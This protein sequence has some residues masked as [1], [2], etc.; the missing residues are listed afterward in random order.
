MVAS[1]YEL[2]QLGRKKISE[3][4]LAFVL[5]SIVVMHFICH[6]L[7]VFMAIY[8]VYLIRQAKRLVR[9][10][11]FLRIVGANELVYS[12]S[13]EPSGISL[14]KVH[15]VIRSIIQNKNRRMVR[16]REVQ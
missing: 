10:I 11:S 1:P 14:L 13:N 15:L 12:I 8:S 4:N 2:F 16:N 5:I 6:I 7:R 9:S 3:N